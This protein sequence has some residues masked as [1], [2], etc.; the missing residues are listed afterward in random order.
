MITEEMADVEGDRSE[1]EEDAAR[2]TYV[3]CT[4]GKQ[5]KNPLKCRY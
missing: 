4:T 2:E 1:G 3:Q 5:P